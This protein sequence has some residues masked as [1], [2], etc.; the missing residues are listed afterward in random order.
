[1][2]AELVTEQLTLILLTEAAK[3]QVVTTP[4]NNPM[5]LEHVQ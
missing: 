4:F 3:L 1:M 5:Q 2:N